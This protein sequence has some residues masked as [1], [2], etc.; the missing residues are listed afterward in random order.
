MQGIPVELIHKRFDGP[1]LGREDQ[2]KRLLFGKVL[3]FEVNFQK[4]ELQLL[5]FEG[6]LLNFRK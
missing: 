4:V 5:N 1:L 3:K 6:S 2:D